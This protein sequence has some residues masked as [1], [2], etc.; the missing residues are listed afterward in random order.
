MRARQP[1][2]TAVA[3][4]IVEITSGGEPS[5]P[6]LA[7]RG[8]WHRDERFIYGSENASRRCGPGSNV[9]PMP[10][11]DAPNVRQLLITGATGTLGRAFSRVCRVRGIAH[12]LLSR[13]EMDIAAPASVAAALERY[14]PWALINTAGFVRV[15]DAEVE[16]ERCRRENTEG[17]AVLAAACATAGIQLVTFSTD[18]VFDGAKGTPYVESDTPQPLNAYGRSKREAELRVLGALPAALVIRSSAFFGPWDEHNFVTRALSSIAAGK[19]FRAPD[20]E[21]VSP[22]YIP[23]LVNADRDPGCLG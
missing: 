9:L 20:D 13:A 10:R 5:H 12:R 3:H 18:L 23:D 16:S 4:A 22:T 7:E 19:T 15:D 6:V 2:P 14:R 21:V 8:W 17:A 11:R 1:R